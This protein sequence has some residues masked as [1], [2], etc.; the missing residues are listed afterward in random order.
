MRA[1][2][3][4][5][6]ATLCGPALAGQ[7][8]VSP[9]RIEFAARDRSQA[10]TVSNTAD[11][12]LRI[13]LD[14]RRWTQNAQGEDDYRS[15]ADELLFFPRQFVVPPGQK[16]VIR[17]GRKQAADGRELAYRLYINE[18]PDLAAAEAEGQVA[19]VVS[20]GV[21]VFLRPQQPAPRLESSGLRIEQGSLV[22]SLKNAGNTTQRLNRL[23]IGTQG[24]EIRQFDHWYLHP[25]AGR[26]YRLPLPADACRDDLPQRIRLETD[27]QVLDQTFLIP[28]SAC[29]GR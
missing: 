19:M 22:F 26:E 7:F 24:A 16:Q 28:A 15:V 20:F 13:A 12:P 27:Q 2:L 6:L 8:A 14:L 17:L 5:L 4:L 3:Y 10:I 1:L 11:T 23:L 25:G 18:Q 21:P 29:Q 9:I